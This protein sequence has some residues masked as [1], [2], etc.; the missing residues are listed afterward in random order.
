M[1]EYPAPNK[2]VNAATKY[3]LVPFFNAV[4]TVTKCVIFVRIFELSGPRNFESRKYG[5]RVSR[6]GCR[7]MP[8]DIE[9]SCTDWM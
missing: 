2:L 1:G 4:G 5:P 8:K 9:T 7:L 3:T 6:E